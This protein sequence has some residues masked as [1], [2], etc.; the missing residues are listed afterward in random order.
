MG[1]RSASRGSGNPIPHFLIPILYLI[2]YS[3]PPIPCIPYHYRRPET[4]NPQPSIQCAFT[5][6]PKP[7]NLN[8]TEYRYRV[9]IQSIRKP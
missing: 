4:L 8:D 2:P 6:N 3:L 5:R 9:T 7:E 1:D